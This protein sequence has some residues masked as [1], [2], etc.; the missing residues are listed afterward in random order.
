MQKKDYFM[1]GKDNKKECRK[2][3]KKEKYVGE[4]LESEHYREFKEISKK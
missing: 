4:F 3:T 2:D 1:K